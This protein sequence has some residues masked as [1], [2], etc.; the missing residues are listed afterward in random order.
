MRK[1]SGWYPTEP[2]FPSP[3]LTLTPTINTNPPHQTCGLP[4]NMYMTQKILTTIIITLTLTL[5]T[6]QTPQFFQIPPPSHSHSHPTTKTTNLS[7]KLLITE[8]PSTAALALLPTTSLL[9]G[10]TA[11]IR[12]Y[13]RI[14]TLASADDCKRDCRQCVEGSL[15]LTMG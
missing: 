9:R 11:P 12:C 6:L 13:E 2:H 15:V 14:S 7:T 10:A 3:T 1:Q 8:A 5:Q 4:S